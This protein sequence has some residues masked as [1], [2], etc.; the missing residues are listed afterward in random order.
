MSEFIS[1]HHHTTFSYQDGYGTPEDHV[2]ALADMGIGGMAATEHGNVTS[3]VK[4]EKAARE[5]GIKPLFGC[6]LYT[7]PVGEDA[8]RFKWHLTVLAMTQTGYQ[9]LLRLVS[10]GWA[11][12]GTEGGSPYCEVVFLVV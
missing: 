9:N 1:L 12:A 4:L 2:K 3:H 5:H 8:G 6:E 11:E 7:G 10:E